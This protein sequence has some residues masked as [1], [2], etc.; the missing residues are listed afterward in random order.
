VIHRATP[1]GA[2]SRTAAAD[3]ASQPPSVPHAPHAAPRMTVRRAVL[4]DLDTIVELRLALLR[5]HAENPLHGRIRADAPL[6]ARRLYAQQLRALDEVIFLA[7]RDGVALGVLRCARSSGTPMLDPVM[8]GYVSSVYVVPAARRQGVL[9][10]LLRAAER[11]CRRRGLTEMRLHNSAHD[12]VANTV[13]DA[14]GFELAEVV[15]VRPL[16]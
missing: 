3:V 9:H 1:S 5:L 10:A 16:R 4:R 13:W 12:A 14:L 15:R 2:T 8:Y 11:W 7:E 6:R